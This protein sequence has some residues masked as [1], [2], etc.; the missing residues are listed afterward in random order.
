PRRGGTPPPPVLARPGGGSE[1][2][3]ERGVRTGD[4]LVEAEPGDLGR[5]ARRRVRNRTIVRAQQVAQVEVD[6]TAWPLVDVDVDES[7]DPVDVRGVCPRLL[8]RLAHR[9][10]P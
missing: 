4:G 9:G 8:T 1:G 2:R 3:P 7:R 10:L 6:V 5:L